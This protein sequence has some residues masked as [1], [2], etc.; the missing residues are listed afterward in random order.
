MLKSIEI[1]NNIN[2]KVVNDKNKNLVILKN[3]DREIFFKQ[4]RN[5]NKR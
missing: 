2:L 5:V 4:I 1:K 3:E